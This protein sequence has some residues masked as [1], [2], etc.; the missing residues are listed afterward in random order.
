MLC[1]FAMDIFSKCLENIFNIEKKYST[2]IV[3]RLFGKY[4]HK[5]SDKCCYN[6]N[7]TYCLNT[8]L[9]A[10]DILS[11]FLENIPN[12]EKKILLLY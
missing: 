8:V 3:T 2:R 4:V 10:I 11:K 9:S 7:P 5:I 12:M 1:S 6:M